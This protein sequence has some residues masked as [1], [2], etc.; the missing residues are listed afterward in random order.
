MQQYLKNK[1]LG[2][3]T[4]TES[5]EQE[6]E[7]ICAAYE[8]AIEDKKDFYRKLIKQI[9][10]YKEQSTKVDLAIKDINMDVCN[11]KLQEDKELFAKENE[12]MKSR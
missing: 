5:F 12:I 2:R 6:I 8:N 4:E 11:L 1:H 7:V 9:N 10:S 3:K